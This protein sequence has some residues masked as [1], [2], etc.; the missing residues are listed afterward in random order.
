[1]SVISLYPHHG[2]AGPDAYDDLRL[3]ELTPPGRPYVAVNMVTTADGV[4]RLGA[5]TAQLGNATDL[6]L[7]LALR[8]QVDC[9]MAGTATIAAERYKG[10]SAGAESMRRRAD[11]GLRPRPLF[12]TITR[13]GR[14][15]TTIPLFEDAG[16]EVVVC[17]TAGNLDFSGC[18]A[19]VAVEPVIEPAQ[20]LTM[21]RDKYN[22]HTLLLEGG[23]SLNGPFFEHDLVDDLFL[24]V[25][26][27]LAGDGDPMPIVRAALTTPQRL[28]LHSALLDDDHL[29]LRYRVD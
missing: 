13:S 7:F 12:A 3:R 11:L 25:A 27:L 17:S 21:L 6:A 5:D 19:Q 15:D 26:P 9:V 14:V 22:V 18:R 16:A 1:M 4:A 8:N 29:Y 28:H 10:P 23:P 20:A 24:T 2:P